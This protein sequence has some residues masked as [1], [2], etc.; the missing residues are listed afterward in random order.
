ML[1]SRVFGRARAFTSLGRMFSTG[2]SQF[3]LEKRGNVAVGIIN[4]P[5]ALNALTPDICN[6]LNNH[7][8]AWAAG[9]VE[10]P[11][12]FVLK[13]AGEKAFCAG[14]DVKAM[15]KDASE[16]G[17]TVGT[18]AP[19]RASS[20]FF[21]DEYIMN[22]NLGVSEIPQISL[23]DGVVMGGGVGI[24][25]FGEY[26]I[27]T[28]KSL[29]AMPET[30]IGLF[31]D[32]GSSA[33]LPHLKGGIGEYLA[34]TGVRL[35]AVDLLAL[36]L[37]T[38]FIPSEQVGPFQEGLEKRLSDVKPGDASAARQ[39]I[40]GL[41]AELGTGATADRDATIFGKQD[42]FRGLALVAA[43]FDSKPSIEA[44]VAA[45]EALEHAGGDVDGA[46]ATKT[47]AAMH[48]CS[49]TSMKV[50]LAQVQRGR[51]MDLK[52]CLE[53][54]YRIAQ[55]CMREHDFVEGVRALLVDK[56]HS[57]SWNPADLKD[58]SGELVE[59]HFA[60]LPARELV[61]PSSTTGLMGGQRRILSDSEPTY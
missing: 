59:S 34:L 28:E 32:V 29:F 40:D 5:K 24:S 42:P 12:A 37:A 52:Q 48:K 36:G 25:I 56:D 15:W 61:L 21:F 14:G 7:L 26:R 47:L 27:A 35:K 54:E 6:A 19:G 38:H 11:S 13:G 50:T 16:G 43:C 2:E 17:D 57:P 55:A 8:E 51:S 31:P 53:M 46:W 10:T 9:S 45:L 1:S 60:A 41:L 20:D 4:R 44:I 33:W 22:Y 18:G 49:P 30:A 58:V 23:W 3:L 39:C